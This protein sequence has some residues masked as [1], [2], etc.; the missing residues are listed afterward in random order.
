M[1]VNMTTATRNS[2]ESDKTEKWQCSH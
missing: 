1:N 2:E